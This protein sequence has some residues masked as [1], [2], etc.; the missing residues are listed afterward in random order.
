[1]T[2]LVCKLDNV[3]YTYHIKVGQRYDR[4]ELFPLFALLY[5]LQ[6]QVDG[7][8]HILLKQTG[9]YFLLIFVGSG[10]DPLLPEGQIAKVLW[11]NKHHATT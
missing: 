9:Q 3:A 10:V 4:L 6:Y 8:W 5:S 7:R 11:I 1:M 2:T